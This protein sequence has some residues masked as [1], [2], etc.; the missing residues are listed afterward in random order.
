MATGRVDGIVLQEEAVQPAVIGI[1]P[2]AAAGH[3]SG[4]LRADE[5]LRPSLR[6]RWRLLL[7]RLGLRAAPGQVTYPPRFKALV[8][9]VVCASITWVGNY[10]FKVLPT[11]EEH[12]ETPC[13]YN[14]SQLTYNAKMLFVYFLWFAMARLSLFLPCIAARVAVVQSR[15]HGFCRTYCVH[16][17]IRDGPLYIFVVGSMLFWFHLMQSPTC[18]ERSPPLYQTLKLYA[19][20]SCMV[21]VLCLVL[22]YWHNKLLVEAARDNV[23]AEDRGAPAA[24][25][26]QLETHKYDPASFGDEEGKLYPSECAICLAAWDPADIIKVTHCQHAFHKECIGNWLRAARTC[27]LCR[28]D[29][30]KPYAPQ[31]AEGQPD[32]PALGAE[33]I[34]AGDHV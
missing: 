32:R 1:V 28:Q 5:T 9:V 33:P 8:A 17:I 7:H 26:E 31:G 19:I 18:E 11:I 25:L 29:L 4:A 16:L 12:L 14:D 30:T 6:L 2:V 20:Y 34:G 23:P 24:T 13:N 10:L 27:A 3:D 22:A 15:T 21:S